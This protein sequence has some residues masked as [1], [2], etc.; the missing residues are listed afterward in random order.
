MFRCILNR[1]TY[2]FSL[3]QIF[4]MFFKVLY[5]YYYQFYRKSRIE[6]EPH[7]STIF[8]LSFICSVFINSALDFVDSFYLLKNKSYIGYA[9]FLLLFIIFI[10]YFNYKKNGVKI[11]LNPI[12]FTNSKLLSL[13]I[14]I[15]F[16]G[17]CLSLP[18]WAHDFIKNHLR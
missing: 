12:F 18:F 15:F 7:T 9:L 17:F 14:V 10:W 16:T 11:I 2:S 5:Y 3:I 1:I 8:L 4:A 6:T 13:I